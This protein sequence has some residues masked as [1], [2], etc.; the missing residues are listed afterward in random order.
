MRNGAFTTGMITCNSNP[1]DIRGTK[2]V[3]GTICRFCL[4]FKALPETMPPPFTGTHPNPIARNPPDPADPR[5]VVRIGRHC[6][7]VVRTSE[8]AVLERVELLLVDLQ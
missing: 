8:V 4:K 1:V 6:R 7:R 2:F 3:P 5:N